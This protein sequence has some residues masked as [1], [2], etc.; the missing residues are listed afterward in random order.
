M[1]KGYSGLFSGT[2]GASANS[3]YITD[4]GEVETYL[5]LVIQLISFVEM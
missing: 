3:T 4:S 2:K 5:P 1:S